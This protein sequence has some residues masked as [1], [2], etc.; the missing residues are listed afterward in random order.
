MADIKPNPVAV[1]Q[2]AVADIAGLVHG[3][4]KQKLELITMA[5]RKTTIEE[6]IEKTGVAVTRMQEE[7]D[8]L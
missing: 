3:I 7:L 6:N 4:E 1:R 8:K 2:K 5:D